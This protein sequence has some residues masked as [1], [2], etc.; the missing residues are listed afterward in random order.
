MLPPENAPGKTS[1]L[2]VPATPRQVLAEVIYINLSAYLS[3]IDSKVFKVAA[4]KLSGT[5]DVVDLCAVLR[6]CRSQV[7][8]SVVEE[9]RALPQGKGLVPCVQRLLHNAKLNVKKRFAA[10]DRIIETELYL[11]WLEELDFAVTGIENLLNA[12]I[13]GT[14]QRLKGLGYVTFG[15][16]YHIIDGFISD[17]DHHHDGWS[18][19][20]AE[21]HPI[22]PVT[23]TLV[24]EAK[25]PSTDSRAEKA[26]RLAEQALQRYDQV[27]EVALRRLK[28]ESRR[29]L[30][31]AR[32]IAYKE[33]ALARACCLLCEQ[34]GFCED[35]GGTGYSILQST[36]RLMRQW[37]A[38]HGITD[39][40]DYDTQDDC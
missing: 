11:S 9:L 29:T 2:P 23:M 33:R 17:V 26:V 35:K 19:R 12:K 38:E 15:I 39:N 5:N 37:K 36:R 22:Y 4:R 1:A 28:A 8:T 16:L 3:L 30:K 10:K 14:R 40:D 6:Q 21:E 32:M 7:E 31:S 24:E 18:S 34:T 20:G 13:P 27:M 25:D